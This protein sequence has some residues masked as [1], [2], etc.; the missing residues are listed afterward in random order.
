LFFPGI[1]CY[2]PEA[3]EDGDM[4]YW[5]DNSD[6]GR[7][8]LQLEAVTRKFDANSK[9]MTESNTEV[10]IILTPLA[11]GAMRYMNAKCSSI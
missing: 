10:E 8:V 2:D 6:S 7:N 9:A 3:H 11:S 4:T 1:G 5:C